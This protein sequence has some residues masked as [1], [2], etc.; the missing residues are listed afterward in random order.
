M[1]A[2]EDAAA[3]RAAWIAAGAPDYNA[4]TRDSSGNITGYVSVAAEPQSARS[5]SNQGLQIVNG[6]VVDT[7][8]GQ[9][10]PYYPAQ[11]TVT[12]I[13][14]PAQP[15]QQP[16]ATAPS[17]NTGPATAS[18]PDDQLVSTCKGAMTVAFLRSQLQGAGYP[19]PWDTASMIAAFNRAACPILGGGPTAPSGA[20]GA[21]APVSVPATNNDK[22]LLYG[23]AAIVLLALLGRR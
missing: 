16:P 13:N 12:W 15:I 8:T 18:N 3:R 9:R 19:G 6:Q 5:E 4:P 1:S 21:S 11:G 7:N 2:E 17:T 20:G 23:V 10:G 14:Q 22:L